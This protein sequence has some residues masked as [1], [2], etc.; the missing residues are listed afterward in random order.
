MHAAQVL[1]LADTHLR[2]GQADRL[3]ERLG[4]RLRVATGVVID[5]HHPE[6]EPVR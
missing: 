6:L 2:D 4:D 3:I 5:D 1:V